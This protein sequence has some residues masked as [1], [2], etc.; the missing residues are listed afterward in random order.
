MRADA[1]RHRPARAL[2]DVGNRCGWWELSS[3][4]EGSYDVSMAG[5]RGF[6]SASGQFQWDSF[7]L[8]AANCSGLVDPAC[9]ADRSIPIPNECDKLNTPTGVVDGAP[10]YSIRPRRSD[11]AAWPHVRGLVNTQCSGGRPSTG[12]VTR[13]YEFTPSVVQKIKD[14]VAANT[15]VARKCPASG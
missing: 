2:Q 7:A 4:C 3:E 14:A 13:A 9:W 5:Y 12:C 6:A 1:C 10:I 11:G 15:P 8:W